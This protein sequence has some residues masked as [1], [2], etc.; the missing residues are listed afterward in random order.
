MDDFIKYPKIKYLGSV[1]NKDIF[2]VI[3]DEIIVEE[4]MDGANMRFFVKGGKVYVGSRNVV[5]GD[6]NSVKDNVGRYNLALRM[7]YNAM[8]GKEN[9]YDG[10]IFFGECMVRHTIDYN[11]E[12][13]PSL[14]L[15]DIY[16]INEKRF[17]DYD[18]KVKVFNDLNLPY[19]PLIERIKVIDIKGKKI[20]DSFVPNSKYYDGKAEGIVFKNYKRQIFAKYVRGKFKEENK[21]AFG[22]SKKSAN[23][24]TERVVFAYVTNARIEKN[25]FKLIDEGHGLDM[26]LM[27][28]LP[29]SVLD[30]V[31]EEH[32][33]DVFY[34]K[35]II[36]F[37]KFKR[38]ITK[39]CSHVLKRIIYDNMIGV[40]NGKEV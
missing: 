10:L 1:E 7:F 17:Y 35:Y 25:I 32:A 6:M 21:M 24:D 19:V 8:K 22:G 23:D 16:D 31:I 33:K 4:K 15:F 20:D 9:K 3:D 29:K 40:G 26:K 39:R 36:D 27:R 11:W 18:E 13:T 14:L 28:V 30:D 38:M 37:R 5:F 2:D 12:K 34:S